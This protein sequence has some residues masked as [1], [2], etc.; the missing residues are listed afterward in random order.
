VLAHQNLLNPLSQLRPL[1]A[2][3]IE[4]A[5]K[6]KQSALANAFAHSIVFN[7][8]VAVVTDTVFSGSCFDSANKHSATLGA[9]TVIVNGLNTFYVTTFEF[10]A[11][12]G[13]YLV[14]LKHYYIFKNVNL[15][16]D[17]RNQRVR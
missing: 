2:W 3:E 15:G 17:S 7:Q 1:F 12:P 6:I 8:A 16:K 10:S 14:D 13:F 4:L 9:A 5:A 11:T